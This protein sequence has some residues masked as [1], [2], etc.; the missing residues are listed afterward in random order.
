MFTMSKQLVSAFFRACNQAEIIYAVL[1][2]YEGLPDVIGNDIDF[3]VSA[4]HLEQF[5]AL[6]HEV[7][8]QHGY[9]IEINLYRQN[10]LKISLVRSIDGSVIK[11][12][13]WW[14]FKYCGLEYLD[15]RDLLFFRQ[16]YG[17]LFFVPL[18]EYEV[19]L[20]FLKELLHM[21]RI[22]ED[23]LP[24]LRAKQN[25]YFSEPFERYF[26]PTLISRFQ[27]ALDEGRFSLWVLSRTSLLDLS[28]SNV[29]LYGSISVLGSINEFLMIRL[30]KK[31][32]AH[33]SAALADDRTR[34]CDHD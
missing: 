13:V 1:R 19:A 28:A 31:G 33:F 16:S 20:S 18:P 3:G 14:A 34:I 5:L 10:V 22:R 9:K 12:D 7:S 4:D 21:N 32:K 2:G 11:I 23:K 8:S 27:K 24:D 26:R 15:I 30:F 29:R 25:I 6:L 17:G